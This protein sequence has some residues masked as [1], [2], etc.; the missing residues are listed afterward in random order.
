MNENKQ[1]GLLCRFAPRN[2]V[3]R[4]LFVIARAQPEAI[5]KKHRKG[6]KC[7]AL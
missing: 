3:L 4:G 1:S 7:F 5:Q 2:D 6:E